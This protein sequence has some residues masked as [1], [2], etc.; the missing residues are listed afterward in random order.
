ME[1]VLTK[2]Y[3]IN[4][5]SELKPKY[6]V[7]NLIMYMKDCHSKDVLVHIYSQILKYATYGR[8]YVCV[9]TQTAMMLVW[10]LVRE[11]SLAI[12]IILRPPRKE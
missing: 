4:E 6:I 11:V 8:G 1:K 5:R 10:I 2:L 7:K 3:N 9:F 12:W